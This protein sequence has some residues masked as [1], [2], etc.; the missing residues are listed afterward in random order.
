MANYKIIV[1]GLFLITFLGCNNVFKKNE[2]KVIQ[3]EVYTS[4]GGWDW[5]RVPLLKPYEVKKIDPDIEKNTWV[6]N[7]KRQL[8]NH[9][10]TNVKQVNVIDST[11]YIAC[12]DSTLFDFQYVKSAWYIISLKKNYEIGFTV[13]SEFIKFIQENNYTAPYWYDLDS[14]SN[15][16]G[17][18]AKLPWFPN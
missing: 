4:R 12:G 8:R 17:M 6:L 16:L 5:I 7:F 15:V 1:L 10:A 18:G 11:I 3:E 14:L 9:A 2:K 13:E